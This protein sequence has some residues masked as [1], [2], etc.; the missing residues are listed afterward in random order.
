MSAD[1]V[2]CPLAELD[3]AYVLGALSASERI[4]FE[5]H[6]PGCA[7]CRESVQELAGVPGLLSRVPLEQVLT[8][9]PVPQTLWPRLVAEA[10]RDRRRSRWRSATV[11]LAVAA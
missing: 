3:G 8:P 2:G 6:L 4:R 7:A 10:Q 1:G 9:E 11:G 5:E